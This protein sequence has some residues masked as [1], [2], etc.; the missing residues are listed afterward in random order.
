MARYGLNAEDVLAVVKN[1][2]GGGEFSQRKPSA[3]WPPWWSV[4]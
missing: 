2:I 4:A 1:G 3:R